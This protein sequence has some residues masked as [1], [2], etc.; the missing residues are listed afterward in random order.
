MIASEHTATAI[1]NGQI[2]NPVDHTIT[3]QNLYIEDKNIAH[4]GLTQPPRFKAQLTIDAEGHYILPG[5]VDL[6]ARCREP[7]DEHISTI[8]SET[9]AALTNGITTLI[10]PPDTNPIIDNKASAELII[11]RAQKANVGRV[12][13]VGAMTKQLKGLELSEMSALKAAGCIAISNADFPIEN[14]NVLLHALYYAKTI[15]LPVIIRPF[16]PSLHTLGGINEGV[17]SATT[18]LPA[19]SKEA[20]LIALQKCLYLIKKTQAKTHIG[21]LSCAESVELIRQAKRQGVPVSADVAIHQLFFHDIENQH[22]NPLFHLNPPLRQQEDSLSLRQGL[23][24]GTIDAICSD[25]RPCSEEHKMLPFQQ[26][27]VGLSGVDTLLYLT[28][29]LQREEGWDLSQSIALISHKPAQCLNLRPGTGVLQTG[30]RADFSLLDPN[31]KRTICQ[32]EIHSRGKNNAFVGFDIQGIITHT[33]K[34]G[35]LVYQRL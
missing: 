25:H 10:C 6:Q 3:W 35:R 14:L 34:S 31:P 33:F 19:I 16:E 22:F 32:N 20:E 21:Q 17:I 9:K 13:P 29:K 30:K 27:A 1:I 12:L 26:S 5:L 7:G 2:V 8:E 18:G 4:I 24:D 11:K 23:Y 28:L 15:N